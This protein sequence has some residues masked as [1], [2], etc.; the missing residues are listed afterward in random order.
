MRRSLLSGSLTGATDSRGGLLVGV[1]VRGEVLQSVGV[2][3][4][5]GTVGFGQLKALLVGIGVVGDERVGDGGD[6]E[7][8][9]DKVR[10]EVVRG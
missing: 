7:E 8:S 9:V 3:D 6:V 4:S 5:L 1:D 2:H 10:S